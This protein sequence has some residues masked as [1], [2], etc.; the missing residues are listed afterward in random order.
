MANAGQGNL[1]PIRS[2]EEA[3]EKGRKGGKA[4]GKA[5]RAKKTIQ[6]ILSAYLDTPIKD[7]PEIENLARKLGLDDKKSVKDLF[8]IVCTLNTL[9]KGDLEDIETMMKL[10]G[11]HENDTNNEIKITLDWKRD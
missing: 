8:T 11:E 10:L 6:G 7:A 1:T 4:S 5:R 2:V 3:R 9:K